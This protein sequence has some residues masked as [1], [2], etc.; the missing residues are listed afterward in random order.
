M[1]QFISKVTNVG[2]M[3]VLFFLINFS[4][5]LIRKVGITDG[6]ST[7]FNV[8]YIFNQ[9]T[10]SSRRLEVSRVELLLQVG[11]FC[12]AVGALV[13]G[14]VFKSLIFEIVN[15][16]ALKS[17]FFYF[18]FV[19]KYLNTLLGKAA[20]GSYPFKEPKEFFLDYPQILHLIELLYQ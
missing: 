10:F 17:F 11:T 1:F 20:N 14:T 18:L 16:L 6:K 7:L 5:L 3:Y 12:V 19:P 8:C 13:A 4:A 15:P 2:F 9:M